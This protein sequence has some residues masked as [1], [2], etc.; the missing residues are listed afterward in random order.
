MK[1]V[2]SVLLSSLTALLFT[3]NVFAQEKAD[4]QSLA[5]SQISLLLQADIN[6]MQPVDTRVLIA[7]QVKRQLL[8]LKTGELMKDST[9]RLPKNRF[10]V[11]IAD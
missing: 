9:D 7:K 3:N 1:L 8:E 2:K 11:V 4:L 10:K 6:Q 5:N